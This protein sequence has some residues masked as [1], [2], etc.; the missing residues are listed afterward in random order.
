MKISV[1]SREFAECM[2]KIQPAVTVTKDKKETVESSIQIMVTKEQRVEKGY[3]GIAVAYDGKKELLSMFLAN[4]LEMEEE[5]KD[6][7]VSGKRL[8]DISAAMNN[9]NEVPMTLMV[10]K[11]C[12][13]KKGG[14][15]VQIPLGEEPVIIFPSNDDWYLRT[16]VDTKELTDLL[17]KGARF[18]KPGDEG[19]VGNVCVCFDMEKDKIQ[20][21][22]T[23]TFKFAFYSLDA[24]F[25]KGEIIKK[26]DEEGAEPSATLNREGS[27]IKVEIDGEQLK[28]LSKFLDGQNTEICV[29]EKYLYFKS[30]TD[31]ALF[32]AKDVSEKKYALA[33][34]LDM[35]KNHSRSGIIH[36]VPKEILDALTVF[37]VANQGEDPF[38]YISRDKS[39]ALCLSTKGKISKTLVACEIKGDFKEMVLNSKILRQ[40]VM[41][42]EKEETMT[43]FTGAADEAVIITDKDDSEDFNIISRISVE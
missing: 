16:T 13:I 24:K 17:A 41:N 18:Y 20:M 2:G 19:S 37:D 28:V 35:A 11:Y 27:L 29:Y 34:V 21:S 7:F 6:I 23:D 3:V 1:D 8:C 12:L 33:G 42:Y 31:I 30:G 9:G 25:K 36:V 40:V 26:M 39:G 32:M 38:V 14:S 10:D 43:V 22:S 5:K 15:E 4:E